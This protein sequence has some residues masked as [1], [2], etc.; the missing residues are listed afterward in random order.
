MVVSHSVSKCTWQ[1]QGG[2]DLP[3]GRVQPSTGPDTLHCSGN[4]GEGSECLLGESQ[5]L[6][7]DTEQHVLRSFLV[8]R[9]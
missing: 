4:L 5:I 3:Q 1:L 6:K 8:C 2:S 7:A 9:G